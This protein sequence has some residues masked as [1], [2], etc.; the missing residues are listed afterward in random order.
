MTAGTEATAVARPVKKAPERGTVIATPACNDGGARERVPPASD[1]LFC[2]RDRSRMAET[3]R[4]S[5]HESPVRHLPDAHERKGRAGF[6]AFHSK[7]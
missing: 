1:T 5:V 6:E 2:A 7:P 4:G 3:L